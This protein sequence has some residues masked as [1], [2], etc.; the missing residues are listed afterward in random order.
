MSNE[1]LKNKKFCSEITNFF[2]KNKDILLDIVLFGSSVKGKN[3]PN[4]IDLLII[5]RD[6]KNLDKSYELKKI[7]KD[8]P[9]EIIDK[10][11]VELFEE[12]FNA[13]ESILSEGYSIIFKRSLSQG[14]G[15]L[16]IILFK[17]ELSGFGKSD[18]MRFY[19]SLYGRNSVG[20]LKS[21]NA[22]KFSE[23]IILCPTD[24]SEKLRE[25]FRNWKISYSDFPI[26][27]PERIKN[28]L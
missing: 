1:L 10:G 16:S 28:I 14:W 23:S 3:T 18:R 12:S 19:Y 9:V 11:Y 6:K 21:C 15:Y 25:F 24:S 8:F 4:D 27:I 7:L 2:N 20:I 5:Y 13:R 26:M 22:S 17:Y